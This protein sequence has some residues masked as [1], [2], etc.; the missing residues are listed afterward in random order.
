MATRPHGHNFFSTAPSAG[1]IISAMPDPMEGAAAVPAAVPVVVPAADA[2]PPAAELGYATPGANRESK[3][4]ARR[5]LVASAAL[6]VVATAAGAL[7]QAF[8]DAAGRLGLS[9]YA[10]PVA[11]GVAAAAVV[12]VLA[13]GARR[14][15]SPVWQTVLAAV[16]VFGAWLAALSLF[17]ASPLRRT[18][19]FITGNETPPQHAFNRF[20][21]RLFLCWV[22]V[23]IVGGAGLLLSR[24][25]E[26]FGWMLISLAAGF[27][28]ATLWG[29]YLLAGRAA[30][31]RVLKWPKL[32]ST[33]LLVV[34]F[35][36]L[37]RLLAAAMRDV[38]RERAHSAG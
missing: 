11:F 13:L 10:T 18:V 37:V 33:V 14:A 17:D 20:V 21:M 12:A 22:T 23:G 6:L 16:L 7:L 26:V 28:S 36:C 3:R 29:G 19:G 38:A 34:M 8:D 30:W 1:G 27:C 31:L 25:R 2:A 35:V 15:G 24:R 9:R 5:A 32:L 4:A